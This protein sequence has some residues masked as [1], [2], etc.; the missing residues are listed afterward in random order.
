LAKSFAQS[1]RNDSRDNVG[2]APG[3][4]RH[5]EMNRPLRPIGRARRG[6]RTGNSGRS[7][8]DE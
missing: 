3:R 8:G 2:A 1:L 4:E 6:L 5:D 7:R